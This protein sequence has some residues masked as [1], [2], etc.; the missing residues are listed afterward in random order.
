VKLNV[1]NVQYE[2]ALDVKMHLKSCTRKMDLVMEV[3][4]PPL[5]ERRQQV[6]SKNVIVLWTRGGGKKRKKRGGEEIKK[7]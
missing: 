4:S 7:N 2:I 3:S 5:K 6:F 1:E